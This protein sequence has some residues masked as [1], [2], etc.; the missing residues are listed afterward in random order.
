M[1]QVPAEPINVQ[2][3]RL[4]Q[5]ATKVAGH[6]EAAAKP[7]TVALPNLA[8][9]AV[10]PADVAA[11][12]AATAI[13]TKIATLSAQMAGKGPQ[14][15]AKTA[16][17]VAAL[18]AQDEQNAARIRAVPSR[19]G[20]STQMLGF[21]PRGVGPAPQA[22]RFPV[23]R[24]PQPPPPPPPGEPLPEG[25]GLPPPGMR[26]HGA[27]GNLN[28]GP[29]SKSGARRKGERHLYDD[30]GVE[31]RYHPPDSSHNPHY[32]Y[33]GTDGEWRQEPIGDL[34]PRIEMP[35]PQSEPG[36]PAESPP[37]PH[38]PFDIS[39]PPELAPAAGAAGITAVIGAILGWLAHPPMFSR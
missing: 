4:M 30:D 13:Q 33:K 18:K 2:P 31:W 36:P 32:D 19:T 23:P 28:M 29:A 15:H 12:G 8:V 25:P 3:E 38:A 1:A 16:A 7:P 34:P 17:A 24:D 5:A 37:P 39:V 21:G 26:P 11:N 10:S 20:D 35:R 6:L 9:A 22:P 14:L 27:K